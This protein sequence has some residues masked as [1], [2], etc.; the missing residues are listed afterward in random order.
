[1]QLA[2]QINRIPLQ[3]S[4]RAAEAYIKE[5]GGSKAGVAQYVQDAMP[6]LRKIFQPILIT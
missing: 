4:N 2:S 3:W 5:R 1:M 6:E